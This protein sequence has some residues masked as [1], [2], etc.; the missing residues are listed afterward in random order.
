MHIFKGLQRFA[1]IF[2]S[3]ALSIGMGY[4]Q[5]R[6]ITGTVTSESGEPLPG[7]NIVIK[8][9]SEGV[10]TDVNGAYSIKVND[11][12]TVLVFL[13]VGYARQQIAVGMQSV[14]EIVLSEEMIDDRVVRVT[15]YT[16]QAVDNITGSVGIADPERLAVIPSGNVTGQLQ[17][18]LSGVTVTGSGLPGATSKVRIRGFAS[19][20]NNDPL[21]V[22]DGVPTQDI[23]SLNPND[24]ESLCV[25]K[26]AGAAAEYGSRAS[27]GVIVITTRLGQKDIQ[28]GY[29]MYTGVQLPGDGPAKDLLNTQEY[30]DLQWLVYENDGTVETHPLYGLSTN[31]E[32]TL[33]SW[34]ANTDWYDVITDKA[35]I[36]KHD[37]TFSGQTEKSRFYAGLGYFRQNGIILHT[38][39]EQY[40]ARFNSAWSLLKNRVHIGENVS[41]SYR[42]KLSVPNLSEGSPIHMGPYRSQPIIP[43]VITVPISGYSHNFIP[44]EYGGT[45]IA[46]RLGNN[47]NAYADLT[48]AKDNTYHDIRLIGSGYVDIMLLN[49]LNFR[50]TIGGTWNNG[51]GVTYQSA[52][53]EN[54]ENRS[55]ATLNESAYYGND[56]VWTNQL[57]FNRSFGKHNI[58]AVA[59]MEALKYGI[60][61]D[62]SATRS[63]YFSDA[64]DF[65]TLSNGSA[66]SAAN[67]NYFTPTKVSSLFAKADYG[68]GDKYLFSATI[69]RDGCSR[70]GRDNR[71]GI[72]PAFSA[73]WRISQESFFQKVQWVNDL[74]IRGSYGILGNQFSLSPMNA[75][76]TFGGNPAA[77]FYDLSGTGNSSVTGFYPSR[78]GNPDIKWENTKITNI[79]FDARFLN[80]SL[81]ITFDWYR[82]NSQDLL[83]NPALPGTAGTAEQP[84][85]NIASMRNSGVDLELNYYKSWGDLR[86]NGSFILTTYRNEIDKIADG[87]EFFDAGSSRIGDIAR[88]AAGH[89]LSAFYGYQVQGL[90]QSPGEI[91]NA[92]S[93]DGAEPGSFRFANIDTSTYWGGQGINPRDRVFIGN[94]SPKFTYGLHLALSFR[95]FDLSAFIYGSKGNDIFN[96]NKWWTDFWPSFQGQ[97]SHDLLYNSWTEGKTGAT[98]PKAS[99]RSN[100]STNTQIC[101]YY[102][103]DG[104]YLRMKSLQI[105]YTLPRNVI[106]KVNM[107]S[108]R[109][110]LQAV[111][112]FTITRYSGLDPELGGSDLSFGIDYGNYPNARQFIFGL[113]LTL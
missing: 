42:S 61:R 94:P 89:P 13:Y 55:I 63:G 24:I 67:S 110:Y 64:V 19:F 7:V 79:G 68:F 102:I 36:Q 1:L 101:D 77:S 109:I 96:Y 38:H 83:F 50:S 53:Y 99:N 51:Y 74:K 27:N 41:L 85:V 86:F 113:H 23:S 88:N 58:Q 52:T 39:A 103:E 106:Q 14:I 56:W 31:P 4:A 12:K 81:G 25:L 40:N 65:R 48:R 47:S 57:T 18:R 108:L 87:M 32:P 21:Y 72:F 16:S 105:G 71:F 10:V 98:V 104:S 45:G 2:L 59:G 9:S 34:A 93:Q 15:G 92:P 6:T 26:D 66:I 28:V 49:G 90:F 20:G 8:G 46:P 54:S 17:G 62:L 100:F 60:G 75:F 73:G 111:N 97:K 70:F 33:P 107:Q 112:L 76:L 69:R 37:L 22:V 82:K 95:N 30:A 35:G 29:T 78:I 11:P 3:M 44:G 5:E 80:N 91:E 43:V 84:F